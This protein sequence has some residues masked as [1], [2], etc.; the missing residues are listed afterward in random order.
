MPEQDTK[1]DAAGIA[2][3]PM[4][5]ARV[6]P[7]HLSHAIRQII[8]NE[9]HARQSTED[10]AEELGLPV[11]TVTDVILLYELRRER[12]GAGRTEPYLLRRSA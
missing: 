2:K 4:G 7:R 10:V 12:E 5:R 3:K 11:R 6:K 9:F 8:I 1:L